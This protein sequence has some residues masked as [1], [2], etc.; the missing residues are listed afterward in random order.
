MTPEFAVQIVREAL[1]TAF[2]LAL[3]LLAVGF[4]MGIL[5]SLVQIV[6][7]IQDTAFNAIPRLLVFLGAFMLALPWMLHRMSSYTVGIL[8]NLSRY[9]R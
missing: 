2:W 5:V 3:P 9:G 7:S 4:V 6:T 1:M 8:G